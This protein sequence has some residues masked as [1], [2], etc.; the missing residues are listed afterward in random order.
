M[1]AETD[2][3]SALSGDS[4]VTAIVGTKIY[5][6]IPEEGASAPFVF[7]ERVDTEMIPSIHSGMPIAQITQLQAVCYAATRES[8]EALGDACVLA[9]TNADFIYS[10]RL[11]EYDADIE[12]F[13][14]AISFQHNQ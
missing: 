13:A 5:S 7:Y 6:D 4:G 12:L 10:G 9:A 2:L 3:Y 14:A 8:A 11:G 1:A